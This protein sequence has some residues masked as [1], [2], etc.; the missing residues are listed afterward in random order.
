MKK[1]YIALLCFSMAQLL[2]SQSR[3][4]VGINITPSLSIPK[5]SLSLP[6]PKERFTYSFGIGALYKLNQNI[7]IRSGI[8]YFQ[9]SLL[10]ATDI[11]DTRFVYDQATGRLDY[12]KIGKVDI[13][14]VYHSISLPLIFNYK[15][16]NQDVTSLIISGGVEFGYLFGLKSIVNSTV[17]GE[18]STNENKKEIIASISFGAGLYQPIA[19]N[20]HLIIIPKY[21]YD[22]YPNREDISFGFNSVSLSAELYLPLN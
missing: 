8:N 14:E 18:S 7:F 1:Y 17:G 11:L 22:F 13:S 6:S 10:T 4:E 12:D 20:F 2:Y 5:T 9:R 21:S 16:S 3:W 15:F 19:D